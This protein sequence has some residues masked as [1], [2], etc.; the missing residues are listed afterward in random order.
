MLREPLNAALA[1]AAITCVYVYVKNKM[2]GEEKV[3]NSEYFKPAFLVALLVYFLT[4]RSRG[5]H[6]T[7]LTEPF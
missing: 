3:K 5:T 2:N 7:R 4:S 1:A 6:E